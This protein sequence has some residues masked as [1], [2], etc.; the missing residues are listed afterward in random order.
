MQNSGVS[1]GAYNP[2]GSRGYARGY[3]NPDFGGK[4]SASGITLPSSRVQCNT[5]QL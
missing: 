5:Y 4:L 3:V 1:D 2:D